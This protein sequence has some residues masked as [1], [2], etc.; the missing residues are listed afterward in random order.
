[1]EVNT[2]AAYGGIRGQKPESR[3]PGNLAIES[4][5]GAIYPED[6]NEAGSMWDHLERHNVDFY[7]GRSMDVY[8]TSLRN[9]FKNN[10]LTITIKNI[11]KEGLI[12]EYDEHR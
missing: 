4:A 10:N 11:P 2:A 8:V 3:A 5:S 12:M 6:Y 9:I 1:M 7:I